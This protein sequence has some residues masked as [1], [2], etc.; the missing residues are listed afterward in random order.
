MGER[1]LVFS[2]LWLSGCVTLVKVLISTIKMRKG[3]IIADRLVMRLKC[4]WKHFL[5]CKAL[6]GLFCKLKNIS[7]IVGT[8]EKQF[9]KA[10]LIHLFCPCSG[11]VF[12]NG[13]LLA[14]VEKSP[15]VA[16]LEK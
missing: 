12:L 3:L 16:K 2:A 10:T 8:L 6:N 4:V 5:N 9:T 1:T 11:W 14:V 13:T 7:K 15:V